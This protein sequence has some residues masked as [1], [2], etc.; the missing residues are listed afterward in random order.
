[1]LNTN[2]VKSAYLNT[3]AA[4]LRDHPKIKNFRNRGMIWAFEVDSPHADF[5]QRCFSLALQHE[6]LLRPM[7]NTVYFMPPYVISEAD[8]DLLVAHTL[9]VIEQLT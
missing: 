1:V 6:I 2:R 7:G 9:R 4:S 5:A 8:M 3:I